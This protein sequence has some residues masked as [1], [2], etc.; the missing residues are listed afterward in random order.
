MADA[1]FLKMA[2]EIMELNPAESYLVAS[3]GKQRNLQNIFRGRKHMPGDD[4]TNRTYWDDHI[5]GSGSEYVL[6]AS[7]GVFWSGN[8]GDLEGPDVGALEARHTHYPKG[9]LILR[10]RDVEKPGFDR[11]IYVLLIGKIPIFRIRGWTTGGA[12][13][14]GRKKTRPDKRRAPCWEIPQDALLPIEFSRKFANEYTEKRFK[15]RLKKGN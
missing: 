9:H 7:V 14:Q 8:F 13:I 3:V 15:E 4:D 11:K 6:A 2:F 1:F 10:Q 12:A 5:E